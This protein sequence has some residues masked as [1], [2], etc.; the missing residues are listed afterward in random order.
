[1]RM[2]RT[3]ILVLDHSKAGYGAYVDQLRVFVG[4]QAL[5]LFRDG[6]E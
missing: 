4:T 1:M 6:L 5:V 3:A 2:M